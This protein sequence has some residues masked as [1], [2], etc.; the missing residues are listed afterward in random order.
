M[1]PIL[2]IEEH[3]SESLPHEPVIT[4]TKTWQEE[5]INH[6]AEHIG[7][8]SR[9]VLETLVREVIANTREETIRELSPYLEHNS[10][11]ITQ[12]EEDDKCDCGLEERLNKL[13]K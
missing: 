7:I 8:I 4:T 1:K 3:T 12:F 9:G 5:K 10:Q 6:T 2:K 11:C 13:K